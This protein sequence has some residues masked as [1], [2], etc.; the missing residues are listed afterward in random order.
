MIMSDATQAWKVEFHSNGLSPSVS[1]SSAD[2]ASAG[3]P[4]NDVSDT[5]LLRPLF[6]A[7]YSAESAR[8]MGNRIVRRVRTLWRRAQVDQGNGLQNRH[9]RVRIP[10]PPVPP[11]EF[12]RAPFHVPQSRVLPPGRNSHIGPMRSSD[13]AATAAFPLRTKRRRMNRSSVK[14]KQ[15]RGEVQQVDDSVQVHVRPGAR[16]RR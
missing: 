5:D 16:R 2:S 6:F 10:P 4:S 15:E 8:A 13:A 9:S 12:D 7:E 1:S 14:D 11:D 3:S